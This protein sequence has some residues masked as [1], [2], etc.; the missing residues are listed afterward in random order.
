M[1]GRTAWRQRSMPVDCWRSWRLRIV[2]KPGR[3]T[4]MPF[5][6]ARKIGLYLRRKRQHAPASM[7]NMLSL[8]RPCLIRKD[9]GLSD[10]LHSLN[11]EPRPPITEEKKRQIRK[12]CGFGCIFC[13]RPLYEYHHIHGY[14]PIKKEH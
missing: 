10:M 9:E 6:K 13:G 8:L 11:G 4:W 3:L 5:R 7:E 14:D 1:R 12:R 2:R